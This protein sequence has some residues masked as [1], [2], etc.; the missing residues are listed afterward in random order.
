MLDKLRKEIRD[1]ENDLL[2]VKSD[3]GKE[4]LNYSISKRKSFIKEFDSVMEHLR[5]GK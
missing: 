3:A 5:E 4:A 1:L 2:F